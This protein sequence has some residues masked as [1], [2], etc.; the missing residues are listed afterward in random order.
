MEILLQ[1]SR[2]EV[3]PVATWRHRHRFHRAHQDF[4]EGFGIHV[5]YI[6]HGSPQSQESPGGTLPS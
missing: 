1:H 2:L 6:F 4:A 3:P 5:S